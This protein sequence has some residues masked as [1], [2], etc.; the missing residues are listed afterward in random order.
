[1]TVLQEVMFQMIAGFTMVSI[2]KS[3]ILKKYQR[4]EGCFC[5][6]AIS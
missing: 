6:V 4:I 3:S 2:L 5:Q 1:M